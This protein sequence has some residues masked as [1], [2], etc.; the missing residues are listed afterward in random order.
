MTENELKQN[1]AK[2]LVYYR[3][4]KGMTQSALAELLSYTDKSVS[5]W[6]R[7]EGMPDA[8]VLKQ[9][10][11]LY[12]VTVDDLLGGEPPKHIPM[13]KRKKVIIG[14][15]AVCL[16]WLVAAT[17]YFILGLCVPDAEWLPM[18]FLFALPVSS[19]VLLVFASMWWTPLAQG[20]SVSALVWSLALSC[21]RFI[22]NPAS[23]NIY[24][25]AGVFQVLTILWFLLIGM[26]KH[27]TK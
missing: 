22:T 2:N 8:L 10:A 12:D 25:A 14:L 16:V 1:L 5:K 26:K 18:C 15:L 24:I 27:R 3:K 9:L 4:R 13:A 7:A 6:E 20:L 23:H 11:T 19:I 21:E 17:T